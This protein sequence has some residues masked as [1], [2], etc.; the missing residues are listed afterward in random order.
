MERE[1][2]RNEAKERARQNERSQIRSLKENASDANV[3][4]TLGVMKKKGR[5]TA[6]GRKRDREEPE[7]ARAFMIRQLQ[8]PKFRNKT[9]T[10]MTALCLGAICA[11]GVYGRSVS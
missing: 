4:Y 10:F 3:H 2:Q 7:R 8:S 1:G 6:S 9:E 11:S 5:K